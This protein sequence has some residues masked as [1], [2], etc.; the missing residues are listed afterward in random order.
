MNKKLLAIIMLFIVL[1]SAGCAHFTKKKAAAPDKDADRVYAWISNLQL[2]NG[3]LESCDGSNFVSLYENAMAAIVF[4]AR[5]DAYGL[6]K[7]EKVLDYFDRNIGE[8]KT[9]PGG[10]GQFRDRTGTPLNGIPHRWLGD[11]AWLLIA[12]NNY[13]AAA[14]NNRYSK[15]SSA[16]EKWIRSLQDEKDGGLWGGYDQSGKQILK[17]TEGMVDAFNAVKGYDRFHSRILAYLKAGSWD[18][19]KKAFLAWKEHEKYKYALDLHSWGYCAFPGMPIKTLDQA[20]MFITTKA[21]SINGLDVT[22]FCFDLDHDSV[23]LEGTG[24]MIVAYRSAGEDY[25]ADFY[26]REMEK[27]ISP[28]AKDP[29][30]AGLPYATNPG[31]HYGEGKLWDGVDKNLSLASSAW[32]LMAKMRY[33]PMRIGRKKGIPKKDMFWER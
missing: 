30:L 16:L 20:A 2:E 25:T 8:L 9:S 13:H 6:R 18:P 17:S 31:T 11:N 32:Y 4:S 10:F 22:G 21:A 15:L 23:W 1:L 3:L 19:E 26:I 7:A 24:E 5:G 29:A 27:V 28:S 33:D 12:V 14:K